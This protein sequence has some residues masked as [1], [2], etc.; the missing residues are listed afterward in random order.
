[1]PE[2]K[3]HMILCRNLV[4]TYFDAQ[5]QLEILA[6]IEQH[7]CTRDILVIGIHETL[8]DNDHDFERWFPR[9]PIYRKSNEIH[10]EQTNPL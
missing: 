10:N 5:L 9:L 7:L 4:F 2:Q 6:N 3:F 1:M 8:P